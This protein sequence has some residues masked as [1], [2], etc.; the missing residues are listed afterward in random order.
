MCVYVCVCV[1]MCV[2]SLT[3]SSTLVR[4]DENWENV[5]TDSYKLVNRLVQ[6]RQARPGMN[7]GATK[8]V[9]S[10]TKQHP[11]T[12]LMELARNKRV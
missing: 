11:F 7:L 3:D 12:A 9:C 4:N 8:V 10:R 5:A 6:A 2:C 1:C